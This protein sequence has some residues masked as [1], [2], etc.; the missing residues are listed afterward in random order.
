MHHIRSHRTDGCRL[1]AGVRPI[2]HLLRDAGYHTANITHIGERVVGTGKPDFNL[3][4]EGP[5]YAGKDW[6]ELKKKVLRR[7]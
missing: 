3:A 6:D 1:S 5:V 2:T 4:K 7:I